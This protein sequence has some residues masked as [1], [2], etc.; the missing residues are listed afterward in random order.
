MR[1]YDIDTLEHAFLHEQRKR[2]RLGLCRGVVGTEK[3]QEV[4]RELT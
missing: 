3:P 1:L 4:P 2:E